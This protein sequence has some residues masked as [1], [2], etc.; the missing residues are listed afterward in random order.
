MGKQKDFL[1]IRLEEWLKKE[2]ALHRKQNALRKKKMQK[3]RCVV[4]A[5]ATCGCVP[6]CA[7][8]A[9]CAAHRKKAWINT[10][11]YAPKIKAE[12]KDGYIVVWCSSYRKEK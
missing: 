9:V 7:R 4:S 5:Q 11:A 3:R 2:S 10:K 8:S 6:G 1:H 12:L